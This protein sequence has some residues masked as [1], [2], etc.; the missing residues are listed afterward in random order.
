[1]RIGIFAIRFGASTTVVDKNEPDASFYICRR[2][3]GIKQWVCSII[4]VELG[5][6][7]S[8]MCYFLCLFTDNK[9]CTNTIGT[10]LNVQD[11]VQVCN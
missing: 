1:M 3:P 9:A 4:N 6:W 7:L 5:V 2:L 11:N 8:V 10:G